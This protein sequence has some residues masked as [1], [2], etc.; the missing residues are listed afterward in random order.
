MAATFGVTLPS[1]KGLYGSVF[2]SYTKAKDV[3]GNPGSSAGSAWSNNYSVND[4][5]ELLLGESQ[6][7]VPHR[8]VG[9]LSYRIEYAKHLATTVSLFYQGSSA[10]RFAYTYTNDINADGVSLDLL[11]I[12]SNS[13]DLNFADIVDGEDHI[14]FTADQ[15]RTA[16]DKFV[17]NNKA[18]KAVSYTHLTL[19]TNREV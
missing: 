15:Q 7:G 6:Y 14:L 9:N 2:Y 17:N 18:L 13:S 10:G 16:F 12:P 4:P 3:S 8:I 11:Y 5:N 1:R 19:P